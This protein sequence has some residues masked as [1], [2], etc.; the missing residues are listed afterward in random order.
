M[1]RPVHMGRRSGAFSIVE[2]LIAMV[3]FTS[4]LYGLTQAMTNTVIAMDGLEPDKSTSEDLRFIRQ[5][6]MAQKDRD[7][8]LKGGDIETPNCGTAHWESAIEPAG[9]SDLFHVDLFISMVPPAAA[10]P[11][12]YEFH[13][14][15]LRPTW[16]EATEKSE[17]LRENRERYLSERKDKGLE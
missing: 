12:L 7:T 6:I 13:F 11:E 15:A 10:A 1:T 14:M 17:L 4:A 9:V 5:E 3:V 2:V 16:S 8:F